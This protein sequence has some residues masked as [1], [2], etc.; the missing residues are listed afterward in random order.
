MAIVR[1]KR[2][3]LLF[4]HWTR[5]TKIHWRLNAA[6]ND[7]SWWH[8]DFGNEW[9]MLGSVLVVQVRVSH[10]SLS[11]DLWR[12]KSG[13]KPQLEPRHQVAKHNKPSHPTKYHKDKLERDQ[14]LLNTI[15]QTLG[16]SSKPQAHNQ[17][18]DSE[19]DNS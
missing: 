8:K 10:C 12:R 19:M 15:E 16:S 13:R 18:G 9:K 1:K 3:H 2:S 6:R 4:L 17:T 7:R 14:P 11:L 5:P